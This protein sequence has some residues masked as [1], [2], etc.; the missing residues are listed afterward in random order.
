M[1]QVIPETSPEYDTTR[2][3]ERPDG[4]HWKQKGAA[5]E[6]GPFE[7]LLECV[8]DMQATDTG[9]EQPIE[10]GETLQEA[11]AEIGLSD[12][13]DPDTG[14]PAEEDGRHLEEH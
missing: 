9:D 2:V 10:P 5:R 7:T 4:F 14:A 6:Y 3:I 13:I 12:G 8:Q 1:K 11:E